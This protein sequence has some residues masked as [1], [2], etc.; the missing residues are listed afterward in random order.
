MAYFDLLKA[1]EAV[2]LIG[3]RTSVD[4]KS[5]TCKAAWLNAGESKQ[6][7]LRKVDKTPALILLIPEDFQGQQGVLLGDGGGDLVQFE[8]LPLG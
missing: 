1:G 5:L 2:N 7:T 3:C 8:T 6:I 4:N